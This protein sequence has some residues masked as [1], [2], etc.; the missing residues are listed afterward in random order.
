MLRHV[1]TVPDLCRTDRSGAIGYKQA[2]CL[3]PL[4]IHPIEWAGLWLGPTPRMEQFGNRPTVR[5]GLGRSHR[6]VTSDQ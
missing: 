6:R 3:A 2:D 5:A 1:G 4:P